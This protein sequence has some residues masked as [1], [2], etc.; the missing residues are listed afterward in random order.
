ML[1]VGIFGQTDSARRK[2]AIVARLEGVQLV[3]AIDSQSLIE[4]CDLFVIA[5]ATAVNRVDL[6]ADALRHGRHVFSDWPLTSDA[7]SARVLSRT[8]HES[9]VE[10]AVD[11][12][13]RHN[14]D[15]L[16]LATR[17]PSLVDINLTVAEKPEDALMDAVD[18]CL[19]LHGAGVHKH[20]AAATLTKAGDL[21]AVS[22]ALRFHSGGLALG[23]VSIDP[24]KPSRTVFAASN[25][26][27]ERVC[28]DTDAEEDTNELER[29]FENTLVSILSRKKVPVSLY[30]LE[31]SLRI[32]MA[33][34]KRIR[35]GQ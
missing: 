9:G 35:G 29:S 22:F 16:R 33:I 23:H 11:R 13:D 8:A 31:E 25:G 24:A 26:W 30:D 18:L 21:A 10:L 20:E 27:T 2:A 34:T 1:R 12:P 17:A 28:L 7:D 3:T 4:S 32:V 19:V 15:V 6:A 5:D 14:K